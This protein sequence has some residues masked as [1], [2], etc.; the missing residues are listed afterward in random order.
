MCPV[1]APGT[2]LTPTK[3]RAE[4][5]K[6]LE[7]AGERDFTGQGVICATFIVPKEALWA[8]SLPPCSPGPQLWGEN[9]E[10]S[11]EFHRAQGEGQGAALQEVAQQRQNHPGKKALQP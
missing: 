8:Q 2:T 10:S 3:S 4:D 7:G 6:A 11:G 9:S 5:L 1:P